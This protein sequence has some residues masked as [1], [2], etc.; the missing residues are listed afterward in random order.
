[1][2][3]ELRFTATHG[4][5]APET[6]ALRAGVA[7]G[8]LVRIH[9]GVYAQASCWARL[10]S[11][12]RHVLRTRGMVAGAARDCVVSH[13]SAV[14]VHDLPRVSDEFDHAVTVIDGHRASTKTSPHLL[15]RPGNVPADDL[16]RLGELSV[17]GLRRTAVDVART[18]GFAD[19]V[20][21]AD[22]VLRRL[23]LPDGHRTGASVTAAVLREREALLGRL[24]PTTHPGGRAARRALQFASPF[25][26]NGGESLLRIVLFELG[27]SNV[28]LQRGFRLADGRTARC[29]AFLAAD[30][31]AVEFNGF[32]KLTDPRMLAGRT[33]AEV[34]RDRTRRDRAL[35]QLPEVHAVVNCEF[36]DLVVPARLA[37]LLGDA[38]VRLDPRRV[39]AAA[40]EAARRFRGEAS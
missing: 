20:L 1:M 10:D 34:I 27:L 21:C 5:G 25:A 18:T 6:I 19:A 36:L 11:R 22:A 12:G 14:A 24:G 7:D 30:G 32:V 3:C 38:D 40:R 23:V 4:D 17:T 29:D 35:C 37:G 39:T 26:E 28:E 31:V 9:R 8:S 2:T 15:R 33:P 16:V 13:V